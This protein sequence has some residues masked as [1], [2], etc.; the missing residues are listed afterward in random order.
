MTV[1]HAE[2]AVEPASATHELYQHLLSTHAISSARPQSS[3]VIQTNLP[4]PMS[5][6]IGR[7]RE[8]AAVKSFL[9]TDGMR[10]GGRLVTL[11]GAGGSGKTRLALQVATDLVDT[12][13]DSVGWVELAA[14]SDRSLVLQTVAKRSGVHEVFRETLHETLAQFLY[15]RRLVL[16]LDNCEHLVDACAQLT[17]MLLSHCPK[18]RILATSREPLGIT[19][20]HIYPVPTLSLPPADVA[21]LAEPLQH[22]AAIQLFVELAHALDPSFGLSADN[23]ATILEICRRSDGIPLAIEIAAGQVRALAVEQIAARLSDRLNLL[24]AASRSAPP[25]H[26]TLRATLDW[27]YDLLT[28]VERLLLRRLA[29]FAG[30]FPF[31]A[32][33]AVCGPLALP[34]LDV[35]THLVDKSLVVVARDL[36]KVQY[37]LFETIREY[38]REKLLASGEADL[39]RM[40]HLSFFMQLAEAA[41]PQLHGPQQES[42]LLGLE[43]VHDNVRIALRRAIEGGKTAEALRLSAAMGLFWSVRG[44]WREGQ[45]WLE[46]AL[47]LRHQVAASPNSASALRSWSALALWRAGELRWR[48][49]DFAG[50]RANLEESLALYRALEDRDNFADVIGL[51][52]SVA[53]EQGEYVAARAFYAESL[54]VGR[55]LGSNHRAGIAL[56]GLGLVTYHQGDYHAAQTFLAESLTL[57]RAAG[58]RRDTTYA[59]NALGNVANLQADYATART[60]YAE[61]LSLRREL[62]YKRGVAATLNDMAN[63]TAKQG[64]EATARSLYMESIILFRELGNQRG[65]VWALSG[66]ARIGQAQG[67]LQSAATLLGAVEALLM[68]INARLDEPEHSDSERAVAALRT[69]LDEAD[70]KRAWVE[71]Q[72]LTVEQA[73]TLAQQSE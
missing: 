53:F 68:A 28:D 6:F 59:L 30:S 24:T 44:Y 54:V 46:Q 2:L 16:V 64:D 36:D 32:V 58:H 25:R 51:L 31:E 62:D 47:A 15:A 50:A 26:R 33:E 7:Q 65:I 3:V 4:I 11:T 35:L 34:V 14:L 19:G 5:S 67:H 72:R 1:L 73:I 10:P 60:F 66:L 56:F 57:L 71:G 69:Q 40:S 61:C 9:A 38:A 45:K 52:G 48:Q 43:R 13:Q 42:V 29:V 39:L 37:R 18:L 17:Y 22:Y 21:L 20:E 8:M 55:A 41:Y 63:V 12:Y 70:F 27:S 23:A 49:C